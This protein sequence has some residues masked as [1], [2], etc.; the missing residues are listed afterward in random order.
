MNGLDPFG[1][2][3]LWGLPVEALLEFGFAKGLLNALHPFGA[4]GVAIAGVVLQAIGVV[5][6][7]NR[8]H[9]I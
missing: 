6:K 2:S 9:S 4:F 8:Q 5:K 1:G 3:G 7:G